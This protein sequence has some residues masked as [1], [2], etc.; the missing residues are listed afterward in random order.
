MAIDHLP[1]QTAVHARTDDLLVVGLSL[2]LLVYSSTVQFVPGYT[3]L[4]VPIGLAAT[5]LVL[6]AGLRVGLDRAAIGVEPDRVRDG[7]RWGGAVGLVAVAALAIGVAVPVFHPLLEDERVGEIGYGLLAYRTL[8]RIPFGTALLEE[9]AFRGVLFGAWQRWTGTRAAVVGSSVVFGLWHVRPAAELVE[10][11]GLT[12][13]A[14]GV[15]VLVTAAVAF[16]AAAGVF[17]CW[18][19]IRSGSLVAPIV[20]HAMINSAATVAAFAV[21]RW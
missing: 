9:V 4:Y 1:D 18:L 13:S 5:G 12:A 7:W 6:L 17:F 20:A 3:A 2:A 15:A 11:N 21:F 19:R 10:I 8:L 14:G 16:T